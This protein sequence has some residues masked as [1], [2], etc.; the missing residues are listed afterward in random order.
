MMAAEYQ[1]VVK[2]LDEVTK[3]N[4][5]NEKKFAQLKDQAI[6]DCDYREICKKADEDARVFLTDPRYEHQSSEFSTYMRG[7][8]SKGTIDIDSLCDTL[9]SLMQ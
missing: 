9:A 4:E 5:E 6:S 2:Q 1:K 8:A 7:E 3:K